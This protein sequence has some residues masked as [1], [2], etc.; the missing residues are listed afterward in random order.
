MAF[1][2][3]GE[4]NLLLNIIDHEH[5]PAEADNKDLSEISFGSA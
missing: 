3:V 2:G 4:L 5:H 1:Q